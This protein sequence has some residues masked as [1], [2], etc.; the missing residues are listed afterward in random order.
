MN[1]YRKPPPR[2][3]RAPRR[4]VLVRLWRVQRARQTHGWARCLLTLAVAFAV[5][6]TMR[7]AWRLLAPSLGSALEIGCA[8]AVA[9]FAWPIA[10]MLLGYLRLRRLRRAITPKKKPRARRSVP[11]RLLRAGRPNAHRGLTPGAIFIFC[12]MGSTWTMIAISAIAGSFAPMKA[13]PALLVVTTLGA[14][15]IR[16]YARLL[17]ARRGMRSIGREDVERFVA[18]MTEEERDAVLPPFLRRRERRAEEGGAPQ[19]ARSIV[20]RRGTERTGTR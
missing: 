14:L 1:P 12:L 17:G 11:W 7:I 8:V 4:H 5:W 15:A 6:Q 2:P 9:A 19:A 10:D 3:P 13:I 18:R 20:D 16:G